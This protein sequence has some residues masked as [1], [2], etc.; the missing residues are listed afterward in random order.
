MRPTR[1]CAVFCIR[2]AWPNLPCIS[3]TA[4]FNRTFICA[5][6]KFTAMSKAQ[7]LPARFN[8]QNCHFVMRSLCAELGE[9]CNGCQERYRRENEKGD[10]VTS[11]RVLIAPT[12]YFTRELKTCDVI[13]PRSLVSAC[14]QLEIWSLSFLISAFCF[15][16]S[17]L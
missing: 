2:W 11:T 14:Q 13:M 1:D 5:R 17:P 16:L 8:V 15:L 9:Y 4:L 3:A 7:R 12:L 6:V 10:A